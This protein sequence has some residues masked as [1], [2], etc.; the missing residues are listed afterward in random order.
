MLDSTADSATLRPMTKLTFA[1]MTPTQLGVLVKIF[2]GKFKRRAHGPRID[3]DL[4]VLRS[5][6]YITDGRKAGGFKTT[7]EGDITVMAVVELI[8]QARN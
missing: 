5:R 3:A 1:R 4:A 2:R 8:N 7:I 6:G